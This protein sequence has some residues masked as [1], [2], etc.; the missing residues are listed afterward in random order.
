MVGIASGCAL[1]GPAFGGL[2]V[3]DR[4]T[5][6]GAVVCGT[7]VARGVLGTERLLSGRTYPKLRRIVRVFW[8]VTDRCR[9]PLVAAVAVTVAVSSAQVVRWQVDPDV[10]RHSSWRRGDTPFGQDWTEI[11]LLV[12]TAR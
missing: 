6:P 1:A 10:A 8:A 9:L 2:P 3:S 7:C 11:V 5:P 12:A 4:E